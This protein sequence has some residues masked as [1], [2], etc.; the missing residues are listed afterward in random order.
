[1]DI[2]HIP[3]HKIAEFGDFEVIVKKDTKSMYFERR[4]LYGIELYLHNNF[5]YVIC[6]V[7]YVDTSLQQ[8]H[9]YKKIKLSIQDLESYFGVDI[10][11]ICYG[12]IDTN[13]LYE[14]MKLSYPKWFNSQINAL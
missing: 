10:L 6:N 3:K 4:V 11:D 9:Q 12:L 13:I 14:Q 1:M 7:L 8:S 5:Y 2:K